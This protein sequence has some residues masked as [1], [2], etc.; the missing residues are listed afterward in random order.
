MRSALVRIGHISAEGRSRQLPGGEWPLNSFPQTAAAP[1]AAVDPGAVAAASREFLF[2]D[3]RMACGRP[4]H[5][6]H[7]HIGR[8]RLQSYR[9]SVPVTT[10]SA[11]ICAPLKAE[12]LRPHENLMSG[13]HVGRDNAALSS[14]CKAHPTISLPPEATGA[15]MEV[16]KCLKPP[17]SGHEIR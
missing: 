15:G 17:D 2:I 6:E 1:T 9:R 7:E 3:L 14:G 4:R 16:T 11:L 13:F 5:A 10:I 8:N 12:G